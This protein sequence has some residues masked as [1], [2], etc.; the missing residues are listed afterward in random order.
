MTCIAQNEA[1][2]G[3]N[4]Q[5]HQNNKVKACVAVGFTARPRKSH[6]ENEENKVTPGQ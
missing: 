2:E 1:R 5:K 3:I 4:I 6:E